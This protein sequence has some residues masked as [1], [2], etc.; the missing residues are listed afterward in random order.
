MG[1]IETERTPSICCHGGGN[2]CVTINGDADF[3]SICGHEG[4]NISINARGPLTAAR[5][6]RYRL[7]HLKD[8]AAEELD[9]ILALAEEDLLIRGFTRLPLDWTILASTL[10]EEYFAALGFVFQRTSDAFIVRLP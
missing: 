8:G 1:T 5:A 10:T 2:I 4:S 9:E 6:I 3:G 7:E